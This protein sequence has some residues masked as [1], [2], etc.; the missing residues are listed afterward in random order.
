[1]IS[2]ELEL[3]AYQKDTYINRDDN[4]TVIEMCR[5]AVREVMGMMNT[6][7]K[8]RMEISDQSFNGS[9]E[10]TLVSAEGQVVWSPEHLW[11][12]SEQ[13]YQDALCD[14]GDT[15]LSLSNWLIN[16][17]FDDNYGDDYAHVHIRFVGVL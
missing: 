9:E 4:T 2:L 12:E 15:Y 16:A 10:I 13:D 7:K 3:S 8:I 6:P 5:G 11:M 17:L 14:W 1:M